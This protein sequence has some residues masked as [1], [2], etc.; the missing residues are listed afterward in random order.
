M[1]KR[2]LSRY[3]AKN[4]KKTYSIYQKKAQYFNNY[5]KSIENRVM[6]FNEMII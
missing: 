1:E 4:D 3:S 6:V 2:N 5:K